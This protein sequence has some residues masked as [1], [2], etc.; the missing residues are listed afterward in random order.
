MKEIH[1]ISGKKCTYWC[2]NCFYK[3]RSKN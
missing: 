1:A 3:K 2:W